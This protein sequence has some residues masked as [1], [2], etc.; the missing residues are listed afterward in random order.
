MFPKWGTLTTA[1]TT[2]HNISPLTMTPTHIQSDHFYASH[3][4][5]EKPPES[6]GRDPKQ[7]RLKDGRHAG[8]PWKRLLL[9]AAFWVLEFLLGGPPHLWSD[10]KAPDVSVNDNKPSLSGRGGR[11]RSQV[12]ETDTLQTRG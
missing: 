10:A 8:S 4:G 9:N 7:S 12:L 1:A 2:Q 3:P 11:S 5:F 6:T